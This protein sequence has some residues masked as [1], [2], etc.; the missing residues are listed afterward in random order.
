TVVDWLSWWLH[1]P[2]T[3]IG[4]LLPAL[5]AG[6]REA[7]R[8]RA[9]VIYSTAPCWTSHTV[10][11][12]LAYC[13]GLRLVADFQD[14]WC[15]SY[16]RQIPYRA[17]RC[18]DEFL[19]RRVVGRASRITCAWDGIRK[20]LVARYPSRAADCE[21]ILNGFDPEE[22]ES[23]EPVR[24]D[25]G[26][27]VFLHAGAF[28]GPRSPEPLM[29]ALRHLQQQAPEM[30]NRMHVV[31]LG[32]VVY[33]GR[34]LDDIAREYGVGDV[35][36]VVPSVPRHEALAW[37]KGADVSLLFGQSG[38]DSLAS[39]PAKTFD[40]VAIGSP[41]LAVGGG[42]EVCG[43]LRRGGC[44]LWT[45]TEDVAALADILKDIVT[46]YASI[47]LPKSGSD[48]RN[49]LAWHVSVERLTRVV[50]NVGE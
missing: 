46:E 27:C 47:G 20:H 42:E 15:G 23:L 32:P 37:I 21:T 22:F 14:P 39:V 4:W 11:A 33:S 19:E 18:L 29:A 1:V 16:W 10:G 13:T 3:R 50:Q 26:R 25:G 30:V 36:T 6:L 41:V 5:V 24:Y 45:A 8:A 38:Y 48:A 28:Y 12:L 49:A 9:T 7:R 35:V 31:L 44:K 43:I 17:H 34:L 2:D 40:Y